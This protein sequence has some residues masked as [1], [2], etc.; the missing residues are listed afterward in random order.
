MVRI[1]L[2]EE[3]MQAPPETSLQNSVTAALR[4]TAQTNDGHEDKSTN[5]DE[6]EDEDDDD[7]IRADDENGGDDDDGDES[8]QRTRALLPRTHTPAPLRCR[9]RFPARTGH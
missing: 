2:N 1:N 7:D 6:G 3:S 5:E 8:G 4:P 9:I